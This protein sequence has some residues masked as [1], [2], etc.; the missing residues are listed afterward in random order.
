MD[1]YH[2]ESVMIPILGINEED[3]LYPK[4]IKK[5]IGLSRKRDRPI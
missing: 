2:A 5:N 4:L 1:I 3:G